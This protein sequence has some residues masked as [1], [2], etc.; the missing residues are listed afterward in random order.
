MATL[1][2][3]GGGITGTGGTVAL[4]ET[5]DKNGG[6]LGQAGSIEERV[7]RPS[8]L[9]GAGT[10]LVAAG[11]W[12]LDDTRRMNTTPFGID[13]MFWATH[14]L[15]GIAS[16]VA[17]AIFPADTQTGGGGGNGSTQTRARR[18]GTPQARLEPAGGSE[19][20]DAGGSGD[21]RYDPAT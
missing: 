16:G 20:E 14:A 17:S 10:G 4:R 1:E 12:Y 3:I 9:Y 19:P 5:L 11:L 7:T 18:P 8:V 13:N 21:G 2:S 15:S 6:L